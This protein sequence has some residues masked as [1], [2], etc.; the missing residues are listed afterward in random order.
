MVTFKDKGMTFY[1]EGFVARVEIDA[2]E[3]LAKLK[4]LQ[5]LTTALIETI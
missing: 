1:C 2:S 4:E 3:A 5:Q